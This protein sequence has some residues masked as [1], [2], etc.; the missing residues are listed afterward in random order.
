MFVIY[1]GF[2]TWALCEEDGSL[3]SAHA[4][5]VQA[6]NAQIAAGHLLTIGCKVSYR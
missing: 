5:E 1:Y 2:S 3:H 6:E 4:N